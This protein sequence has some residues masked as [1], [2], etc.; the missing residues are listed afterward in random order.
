MAREALKPASPVSKTKGIFYGWWIVTACFMM[1]VYAGGVVG[2]G[3]TS[4][5]GPIKAELG[6]TSSQIAFSSSLRGMETGLMAPVI[7]L[8]VDRFG[9]KPIM[10]T[11]GIFAGLGLMLMSSVQTLTMFYTASALNALGLSFCSAN[12]LQIAVATWF[13][14]KI[15]LALGLMSCGWGFSGLLIPIVVWIVDKFGWRAS[16]SYFGIGM[17]F[18][19]LPL[20]LIVRR[21]PEDYGMQPDGEV[22]PAIPQAGQPVNKASTDSKGISTRQA[23]SSRAFWIIA[24]TMAAQNMI[25]GSVSTHVM[26]YLT[27]IG[28]SREVAGFMASGIPMASIL[29]RFSFGWLGDRISTKKLTIFGFGILA[30]GML[31]FAYAVWG[32]FVIA[33]FLL[34]FGIGFGGTNTMRAVLPQ[35]YFGI[36]SYGTILGLVMGVGTLGSMVGAPLAG[37]TYDT[38]KTY[39]PIWLIYAGVAALCFVMMLFIPTVKRANNEAKLVPND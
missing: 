35:T 34:A 17:F 5:F 39:Q 18:F 29:G 10:F 30:L 11:G 38:I 8:L 32:L 9:P 26:P 1:A 19:I 3:F 20:S 2:W 15:S 23:L 36:K 6:W 28:Y 16:Q 31:S 24:V 14:R 33:I 37:Y 12:A 13:R 25:V 7:G 4:V 21:R 22:T 27:S